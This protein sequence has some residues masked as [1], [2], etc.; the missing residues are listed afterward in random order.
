MDVGRS[1]HVRGRD[2]PKVREKLWFLSWD[3]GSSVKHHNMLLATVNFFKNTKELSTK[4]QRVHLVLSALFLVQGAAMTLRWLWLWSA[5][6][7]YETEAR[8]RAISS[9]QHCSSKIKWPSASFRPIDLNSSRWQLPFFTLEKL[10]L[11]KFR[12]T[13]VPSLVYDNAVRENMPGTPPQMP[14]ICQTPFYVCPSETSCNCWAAD[15]KC[16]STTKGEE[17]RILLQQKNERRLSY[18]LCND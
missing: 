11:D 13:P 15:P 5:K 14:T 8:G 10:H 3:L 1:D 9:A 16:A 17:R 18:R 4:S 12:Y 7:I 6:Y 2:T